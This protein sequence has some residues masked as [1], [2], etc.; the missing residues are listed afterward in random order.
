MSVIAGRATGIRPGS[1]K[2]KVATH[3][4]G[5]QEEVRKEDTHDGPGFGLVNSSTTVIFRGLFFSMGTV[6]QKT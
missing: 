6:C 4:E 1:A 2:A 5:L 3:T